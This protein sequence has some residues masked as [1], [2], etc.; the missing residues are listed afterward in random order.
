MDQQMVISAERYMPSEAVM[1]SQ[2]GDEVILLDLRGGIYHSLNAVGTPIWTGLTNGKSQPEIVDALV[3]KFD[4]TPA[5]AAND[6]R[7][8]IDHLLTL[9]LVQRS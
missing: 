9:G 8:F 5:V 4:V 3:A 7:A 1:A 6:V 2:V